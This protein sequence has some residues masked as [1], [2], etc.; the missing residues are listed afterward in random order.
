MK[1]IIF[2]PKEDLIAS[3]S[4]NIFD[5][6]GNELVKTKEEHDEDLAELAK[7][8]SSKPSNNFQLPITRQKPSLGS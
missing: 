3:V 8:I 7:K 5:E 4:N 6:C 2:T 1:E